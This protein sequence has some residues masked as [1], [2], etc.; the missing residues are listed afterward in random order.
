[1]APL[2]R[3]TWAKRGQTPLLYQRTNSHQ[4][5]SVI[6]AL[7]ITPNWDKAHFY[8]RLHANAN[9]NADRVRDFLRQLVRQN[10][11]PVVLLWDRLQAHRAKRVQTFIEDTPGLWGEYFP[12]YAP[13]LNPAEQVWNYLKNNPLANLPLQQVDD[14]ADVARHHGRS[15]QRKQSLLRSL[16]AHTPLNIRLK[17]V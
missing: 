3:R 12:S 2:V 15:L 9:I 14:L 8:F 6:G 13:E 7:C 10:N 4:K 16:L 5:V 11:T 17:Q 1:M